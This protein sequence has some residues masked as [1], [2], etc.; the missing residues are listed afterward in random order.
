MTVTAMAFWIVC[1]PSNA[2]TLSSAMIVMTRREG[3][4]LLEDHRALG[5][6][7]EV[8]L[9]RSRDAAHEGIR[10]GAEI[11]DARQPGVRPLLADVRQVGLAGGAVDG[12]VGE[13]GD[14][15]EQDE[16]EKPMG[17]FHGVPP[18]CRGR[19]M[20]TRIDERTSRPIAPHATRSPQ[21]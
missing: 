13:A 10:D 5:A 9:R 20:L 4:A 1:E 21:R 14:D 17:R 6:E 2:L 15:G 7:A 8:V 12:G 18:S 16:R 11:G 19:R 3:R